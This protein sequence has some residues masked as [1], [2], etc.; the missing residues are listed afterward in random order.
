MNSP[1]LSP[2]PSHNFRYL[3]VNQINK[4]AAELVSIVERRK[5][6][7]SSKSSSELRDLVH[8]AEEMWARDEWS[9]RTAAEIEKAAALLVL[10]QR[11][12]S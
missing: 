6:E 9:V 12:Q 3:M 1:T 4:T 11:G 5:T 2:R 8:A 10:A 7:F